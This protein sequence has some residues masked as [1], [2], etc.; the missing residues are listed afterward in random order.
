MSSLTCVFFSFPIRKLLEGEETHFNS[1]MSFGGASYSSYQPRG[2]SAGS[3]RGGQREKDGAK[4]E[5]FKESG[6]D[7]EQ[8]DINSNN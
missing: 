4:K 1:G 8:A 5:S 3:S 2:A 6:E 7:K